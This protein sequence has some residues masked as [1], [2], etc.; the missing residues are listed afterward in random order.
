VVRTQGFFVDGEGTLVERFCFLI[1]ILS[2]IQPGEIVKADGGVGV[3]RPQ[4]LLWIAR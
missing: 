2:M 1:V 3:L 4:Y